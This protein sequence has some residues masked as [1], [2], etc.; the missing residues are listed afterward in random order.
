MNPSPTCLAANKI[1]GC[2][3]G[4]HNSVGSRDRAN[5]GAGGRCLTRRGS[6]DPVR[7]RRHDALSGV[8]AWR[9]RE[10][11]DEHAGFRTGDLRG[12]RGG[13]ITR[14]A[15]HQRRRRLRVGHRRRPPDAAVPRSAG[16]GAQAA[17]GTDL[18]RRQAGRDGR[19]RRP[20]VPAL[21]QPMGGRQRRAAWLAPHRALP[22]RRHES[23][24]ALRLRGRGDRQ[25]RVDGA[26]RQ[27]DLCALRAPEGKR[28]RAADAQG[29]GQLPRLSRDHQG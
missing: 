15:L 22:P 12:S 21:R 20:R 18:A 27:H 19:V 29:P 25:A 24:L 8:R 3:D 6:P 9:L 14:V 17:G 23:G 11:D 16:G 1:K 7:G 28:T 5:R 4:Y 2:I 26:G 10:G 13:G